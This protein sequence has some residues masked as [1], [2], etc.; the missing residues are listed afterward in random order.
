MH[1]VN[2]VAAPRSPFAGPG[3]RAP[4]T[5]TRSCT[6]HPHS[7]RLQQRN[8]G[9]LSLLLGAAPARQRRRAPALTVRLLVVGSAAAHCR[10]PQVKLPQLRL[11]GF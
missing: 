4:A 5:R 9:L 11:R 3:Y 10:A 2:P 6:Q 1:A 7:S 8:P